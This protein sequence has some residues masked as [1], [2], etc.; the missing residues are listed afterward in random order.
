[1]EKAIKKAIEGGWHPKGLK[2]EGYP[3][4]W[5]IQATINRSKFWE[6]YCL[7][8]LFWQALG[9]AMGWENGEMVIH[10]KMV[11][12]QQWKIYWHCFID[13]LAEGKTPDEF[14]NELLK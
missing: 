6:R 11:A 4:S 9:K 5:I 12:Y 2:I 13:A 10:E 3:I 14:F 7:E 8:P 1:M